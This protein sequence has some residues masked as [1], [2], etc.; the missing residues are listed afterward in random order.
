MF[1]LRHL[2]QF[3][4]TSPFTLIYLFFS[5]N[6]NNT[7]SSIIM[8]ENM[9]SYTVLTSVFVLG[10]EGRG[11]EGMRDGLNLNSLKLYFMFT[12]L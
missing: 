5:N 8:Y 6:V 11:A 3:L 9:L 1:L 2:G 12:I 4:C 7:L 10:R